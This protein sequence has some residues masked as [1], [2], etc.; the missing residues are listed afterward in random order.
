MVRKSISD[1]MEEVAP[2]HDII[3]VNILNRLIRNAS[4]VHK[5]L[6]CQFCRLVCPGTLELV[7]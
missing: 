1:K 6:F 3:A 5:P 2:T 4:L 7:A